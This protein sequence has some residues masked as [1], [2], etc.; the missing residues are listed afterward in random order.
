MSHAR[1]DNTVCLVGPCLF[2]FFP[3]AGGC[4]DSGSGG[5]VVLPLGVDMGVRVGEG[6]APTSLP[7]AVPP[8]RAGA[9]PAPL[10]SADH[11]GQGAI[12]TLLVRCYTVL[13]YR[14]TPVVVYFSFV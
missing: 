9:D 8:Q 2:F 3:V 14:Y 5:A 1:R 11:N 7:G 13:L 6:L 10:P 12:R 4:S